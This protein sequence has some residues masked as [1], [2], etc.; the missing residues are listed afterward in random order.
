MQMCEQ[1]RFLTE[2]QKP[3]PFSQIKIICYAKDM[4]LQKNQR[5]IVGIGVLIMAVVIVVIIAF[6]FTSKRSD[7]VRNNL[8]PTPTPENS[9]NTPT[10]SL[11]PTNTLPSEFSNCFQPNHTNNI[12]ARCPVFFLQSLQNVPTTTIS[13]TENQVTIYQNGA[14][15]I[16]HRTYPSYE[17]TNL[18]GRYLMTTITNESAPVLTPSGSF[19]NLILTLHSCTDETGAVCSQYGNGLLINLFNDDVLWLEITG[20][21]V[22]DL[23]EQQSPISLVRKTVL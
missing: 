6:F 23:L 15:Y 3:S 9:T 19:G 1:R 17:I 11:M 4:D 10:P 22:S 7:D 13:E 20:Q 18:A 2:D 14:V 21:V 12:A 5:G 16:L 8:N